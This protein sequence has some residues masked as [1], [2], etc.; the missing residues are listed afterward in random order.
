MTNLELQDQILKHALDL[1]RLS[2]HDEAQALQIIRDMENELKQLLATA[3]F[4]PGKQREI[5]A[6]I[7]QA[8][9]IIKAHYDDVAGVVDLKGIAVVVAEKTV[10]VLQ[11]VLPSVAM[12]SAERLASLAKE[13][14]IEGSPAKAWWAKQSED[15]AFKFAAQVREGMLLDETQE[16]I[17]ARVVGRGDE[18]GILDAA[19][20]NVRSLVHSSVMTAANNARLATFR[21]NMAPGDTLCWLSTLDTRT[22]GQCMA[23]DG[24]QWDADGEPVNGNTIEWNGGA[25]AHFGC[26]CTLSLR[27]GLSALAA[28]VGQDEVDAV[29]NSGGRASSKG[30]TGDDTSMAGFLSRLS[31]AEQDEMLGVGRAKLW[32]GGVITLRDLVSGTGRELSLSELRAR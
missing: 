15:T 14:L 28:L 24:A 9:D 18:V 1:Q 19:R 12:P 32:R 16:Q 5:Q 2:A 10:D 22:C 13:V 25:P 31:Q 20:R 27:P 7:K 29:M 11:D 3:E 8:E 26:R 30:P 23:L 21:K 4:A 17:V 6:L